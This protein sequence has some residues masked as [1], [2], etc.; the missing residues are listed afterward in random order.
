MGL[1]AACFEK[2]GGVCVC[3]CVWACVRVQDLYSAN[4]AG[5]GPTDP[6]AWPLH[7]DLNGQSR[8]V[9]G[10]GVDSGTGPRTRR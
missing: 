2:R 9:Q 7:P 6:A 4:A 10:T 1:R 5:A 3:V 8:A